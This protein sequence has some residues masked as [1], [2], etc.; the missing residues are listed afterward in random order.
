MTHKLPMQ[1]AESEFK[2]QNCQNSYY[3]PT[4]IKCVNRERFI[5][6]PN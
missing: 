6:L 5:L 1:T 2:P 3:I 4:G